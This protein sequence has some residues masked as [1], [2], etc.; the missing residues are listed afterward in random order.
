MTSATLLRKL[1]EH[2]IELE[3]LD[4][5]EDQENIFKNIALKT[6]VKN[7]DD[8][9]EYESTNDEDGDLIKRFEKFLSK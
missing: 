4:K 9:Q 5:H 6:R 2:E 7:H 3:I 8:N 1:Q